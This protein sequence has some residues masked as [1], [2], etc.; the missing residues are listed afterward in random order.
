MSTIDNLCWPLSNEITNLFTVH[1]LHLRRLI[2]AYF[3]STFNCKCTVCTFSTMYYKCCVVPGCTNSR[4]DAMLHK[5]PVC[6]QR[7]KQWLDCINSDTLRNKSLNEIS[8]LQ[9]CHRHF[10]A[11]FVTSKSRL[12]IN[13]YP[14]L[15]LDGNT[16]P[17]NSTD[18]KFVV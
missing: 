15:F 2:S 1:L 17:L 11:R 14:T 5:F 8:G 4:K 3:C 10:E 12:L 9:V 7:L 18:G 6:S 16:I 13:A